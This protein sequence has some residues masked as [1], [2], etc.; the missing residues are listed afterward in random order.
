[1]TGER[2]V[3]PDLTG[4]ALDIGGTKIV[5][6][7]FESG[8]EVAR[9]NRPTDR[10]MSGR[11]LIETC[12]DLLTQVEADSESPLGV[13]ATGRVAA[14]GLW[15]AVNAG[16]L[17]HIEN[18][19]LAEALASGLGRPVFVLN[20]AAAAAWVEARHGAA[21]DA[22]SMIYVTVSTGVGGGFVLNNTLLTSES[23]LAGHV[24]FMSARSSNLPCGSGRVGTIESIASGTA[25]AARAKATGHPVTAREVFESWRRGESWAESLVHDSAR[26]IADLGSSLR[27]SL[28]LDCMVLGGSVG[29]S[30]GY[31][32]LV[33]HFLAKEPPL[34]RIE[35]ALATFQ[36][37]SPLLG[38]LLF[39]TE[40]SKARNQ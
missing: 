38:A 24:G 5:A 22:A 25:I 8:S 33:D 6:A 7:R 13:A 9:L 31:G 36:H 28:G 11:G 40:Q 12:R 1:M 27:A 32:K 30:E 26:T 15:S 34:F 17:P 19:P 14:S 2:N 29:L 10:G 37:D 39:A 3:S 35:T 20:D 4:A 18:L 21:A 16:T 23:G